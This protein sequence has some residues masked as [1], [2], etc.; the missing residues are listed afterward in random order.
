MEAS[1]PLV[2][3]K[4][5]AEQLSFDTAYRY[6]DYSSGTTTDTYKFGADWAPVQDIRFRASYQRAVRA[7]NIVELFTAQGFNLFD[8]DGDPCGAAIGATS[9]A[10]LAECQATGVPAANYRSRRSTARPVSTTSLQGGNPALEPE[11]STT[12]SYGIVFTPG[13]APGLSVSVDY[14][15][16]EIEELISTFGAENTLNACYQTNDPAACARIHRNRQRLAVGRRRQ[17]R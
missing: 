14:F 13:F 16:I 3:G 1:V 12:V 11:E 8:M 17:R 7:P 5:G 4:T 9:G 15:D 10:S 2:Q 6:S